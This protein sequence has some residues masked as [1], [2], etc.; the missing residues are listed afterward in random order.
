MTERNAA[1][2]AAYV[3]L[4]REDGKCLFLLRANTGYMDGRYQMPSGHVEHRELPSA[5]AVREVKEETGVD[6]D[7]ADLELVHVAYRVRHDERRDRIDYFYRAKRWSGE[8]V[9]AEP[10]KCDGMEWARLDALPENTVPVI[11]YAVGRVLAG[12][13]HSELE[14]RDGS[15]EP[16]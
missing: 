11:A 7:P 13:R 12:E 3:F 6:I 2:P 1:I 4:E 10:H 8:I 16:R 15:F 9:N 5:A 14:Q